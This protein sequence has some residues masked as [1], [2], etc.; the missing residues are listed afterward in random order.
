MTAK[1]VAF[2]GLSLA[3]AQGEIIV[4]SGESL[5]R[6]VI[7]KD[8]PDSVQLAAKEL[9]EHLRGITGDDLPVVI[10]T[11]GDQDRAIFL[12]AAALARKPE[13]QET[14]WKNDEFR[15]LSDDGNLFIA[16]KDY[17]GAPMTSFSGPY[18]R[19]ES[20]NERLK[21]GAF[22]NT[23]TLFGVYHFLEV[24]GGIRWYMPGELGTV[25][26]EKVSSLRL[27]EID[28]RKAPAFDERYAYFCFFDRSDDDALWYRWAGFGAAYPVA[29]SHSFGH[30]F[31]KYKDSH[32][33]YFALING[34]RDFASLS[35]VG[36]GN[37]NLSE[38]GLI[39]AAVDAADQ[40]FIEN[41][42]QKIFPLVPND[43]MR[44]IS[45]DPVS[46]SQLEPERQKDGGLFS[47]YV[48]GFVNKV[49]ER[50]AQKHPDKF[51]GCIAYENYGLP[52]S[53]IKK[54]HPSVVVVICKLRRTFFDPK[55]RV[56]SERRIA[57]WHA[58]AGRIY[59]WE[60][61]CDILLNGGWRGYPI[62]YPEIVQEDLRKLRGLVGGEF[63]QAESWMPSQYV[64]EPEK[65][66]I[67]YPG[68]QHP[69]LYVTARLLWNPD[70]NLAESLDEYYRLFYGPAA[71]EMRAFW[72]RAQEFWMAQK[73]EIPGDFFDSASISEMVGYLHEAKRKT[74]P[75]SVYG[76]RVALIESEFAPATERLA[77]LKKLDRPSAV[78][79]RFPSDLGGLMTSDLWA[80][81]KPL[82]LLDTS[83]LP[84]KPPTQVRVAWNDES[85]LV[86]M[87]CFEPKIENLVARAARNDAEEIWKDDSVE[88]FLDSTEAAG[89]DLQ[90][91]VNSRGTVW[92]ALRKGSSLP[93]PLWNSAAS[94]ES[95]VD[96]NRWT[97]LFRIPWSDLG[98]T[99]AG[100]GLK[101]KANFCRN[102]EIGGPTS[103]ASW[104][105]MTGNAYY[106]PAEFGTLILE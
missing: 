52:P 45:E 100:S 94:V 60:Y 99:K 88:L 69:L 3:F 86:H 76:K 12:G 26:P 15:I 92:D 21:I 50:V 55:E 98:L 78:V 37:Y 33:E 32:P 8:A 36:P 62:F 77:R 57:E 102:R 56:A 28:V 95:R 42:E 68:L 7:A 91:I 64:A 44:K 89:K 9:Q 74:D 49:A 70:L 84:S 71:G 58:K 81:V 103:W 2:F 105:P 54:L 66:R 59:C 13:L 27:P 104:I 43:G 40:F 73:A 17:H 96:A 25:W 29:V 83:F 72:S 35:S 51:V 90:F 41:P 22:G 18:R 6:I 93:D 14:P 20:Y 1:V 4:G 38:P 85:L 31:Y 10:E 65:I 63:I 47:N 24:F 30:F 61:Y 23:G 46:Q 11:S 80:G 19:H 97:V 82:R 5:K 87:T 48:W 101:L 79:N 106:V 34:N 75:S 67:N 53:N 39:N 16:G